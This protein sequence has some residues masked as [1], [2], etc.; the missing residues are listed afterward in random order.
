MISAYSAGR[1]AVGRWHSPHL[2]ETQA[3]RE[4]GLFDPEVGDNATYISGRDTDG[5]DRVAVGP[6]AATGSTA[7]GGAKLFC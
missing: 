6:M 3:L 4:A 2:P 1:E 7:F 5:S